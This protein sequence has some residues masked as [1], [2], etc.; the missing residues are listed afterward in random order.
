MTPHDHDAPTGE[1]DREHDPCDA[2]GFCSSSL[3]NTCT[4]LCPVVHVQGATVPDA[5]WE[6][7]LDEER[8][9]S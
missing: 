7:A 8:K 1:D 3:C 6:A 4:G 9:A 5:A 2:C